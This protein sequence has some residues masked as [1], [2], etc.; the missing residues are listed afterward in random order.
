MAAPTLSVGPVATPRRRTE[1]HPLRHL[2]VALVLTPIAITGLGLLMIYSSTRT[3]LEGQDLS[4]LYYVQRQG[5]AF[6]LGMIGMVV[7]M[8]V[9]YRRIRD[10][11]PIVYLATL[12]LLVGVLALGASRKGAQAWFQVGPL[13]FQP[14]EI[15]KIGV[16][17]AVAGYCHH[18]RGDLDAWRVAVVLALAAIPIGLV[19]LQNDLGSAMIMSIA[20]ATILVVAGIRGVHLV[21]LAL[22][23]VTAL[24]AA[25]STGYFDGY[26]TDRLLSF[27]RQSSGEVT[28]ES[29][30]AE[31]SL[32]QSKAAIGSGGV[33]GA[34]L[35]NGTQ[36]RLSNVPEQH[37]DF[38]FSVVGEELGFA[39]GATLLA[40]YALFLWR[41]YR[42]AL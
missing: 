37:T 10:L 11:Y 21:V 22:I 32:G 40:L 42:I 36:T 1:I 38:I 16:I 8:A 34:G 27:A 28:P 12:P 39:G 18:H 31:Y 6:L 30:P 19:L 15:A 17:V 7:A 9:D 25:V 41:C 20:V 26:R 33:T 29:S 14:S 24:G 13:Q 4:T 5:I 23:A 2:D 3:R 35:F